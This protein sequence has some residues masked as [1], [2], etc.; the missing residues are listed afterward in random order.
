MPIRSDLKTGE[1]SY[2]TIKEDTS[3]PPQPCHRGRAQAL[4]GG[5]APAGQCQEKAGRSNPL[6]SRSLEWS[7]PLPQRWPYRLDTNTIERSIRPIA[8]NRKNGLFAGLDDSSDNWA[9]IATLIEDCKLSG[10]NSHEWLTRTLVALKTG[11]P[12]N[13]LAELMPSIAVASEHRLR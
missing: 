5:R 12:A 1:V 9:V 7:Y 8:L 2:S 11:A 10:I 13:R 3:A 4:L 6:P